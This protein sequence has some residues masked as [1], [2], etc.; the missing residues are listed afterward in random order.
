M[1]PSLL[2]HG[3]K[4]PTVPYPIAV[5]LHQKLVDTGN[6]CEFITMTGCGHGATLPEWKAKL[7]G[8][9]KTFLTTQKI[10]PVPKQE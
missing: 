9:M 8:L 4:D 3:D 6:P 2:L 10:L 5:E 1:P 7:P